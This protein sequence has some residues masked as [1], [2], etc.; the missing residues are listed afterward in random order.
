M[1]SYN[2]K[3]VVSYADVTS[4]K[5]S[6][7][8]EDPQTCINPGWVK[9]SRGA[10]GRTVREYGPDLTTKKSI[11]PEEQNVVELL[12]YN[13]DLSFEFE[14][15]RYYHPYQ[16]KYESTFNLSSDSEPEEEEEDEY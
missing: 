9:L 16:E 14:K 6:L 3:K 5:M 12:E 8:V 4:D 10:H 1:Q 7:V 2:H 11:L 15:N 13:I